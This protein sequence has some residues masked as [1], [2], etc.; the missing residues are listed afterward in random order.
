MFT[1]LNEDQGETTSVIAEFNA[2]VANDERT[3]EVCV[4]VCACVCLCG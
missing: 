3:E 4:C 1:Q 2:H